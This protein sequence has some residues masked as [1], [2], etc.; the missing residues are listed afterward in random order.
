MAQP[1]STEAPKRDPRAD[2]LNRLEQAPAEHAEALLAMYDVLQGLHDRG[3]LDLAR[4][5]LGSGDEVLDILVTAVRSPQSIRGIRNLLLLVNMLGEIE[6]RVLRSFTQAVPTAL[7]KAAEDPDK[8]GLWRLIK[9]FL[10]N[11]DFRHG[12]AVVN[13][14]LDTFGKS[15]LAAQ[16]SAAQNGRTD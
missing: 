11:K 13:T 3:A 15:L 14:L 4:G 2:L 7:H 8:P 6:P 5:A 10:W 1:I 9:D 12:M 16:K